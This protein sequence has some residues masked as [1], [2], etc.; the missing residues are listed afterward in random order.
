MTN[1]T[2]H[3]AIEN[4]SRFRSVCSSVIIA[5]PATRKTTAPA[6]LIQ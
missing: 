1:D 4:P 6:R 5:M 3:V 2:T